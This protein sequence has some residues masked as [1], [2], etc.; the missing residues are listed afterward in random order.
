MKTIDESNMIEHETGLI[1]QFLDEEMKRDS[2]ARMRFSLDIFCSVPILIFEFEGSSET[3]YLP[4]RFWENSELTNI[5]PWTIT[6]QIH[7]EDCHLRYERMFSLTP[8][9]NAKMQL[10]RKE[11]LSLCAGQLDAIEDF[12]YSDFFTIATPN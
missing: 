4:V 1:I 6:I 9:Q 2:F 11:Q 7:G 8:V 5:E 12:I 3:L 10:C